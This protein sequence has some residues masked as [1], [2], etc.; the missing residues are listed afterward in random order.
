MMPITKIET[1]KT[2]KFR[3]KNDLAPQW[4]FRLFVYSPSG[5]GKTTMILNLVYKYLEYDTITIY[6]KNADQDTYEELIERLKEIE[7]DTNKQFTHIGS[8]ADEILPI[9]SYDAE[10][11]NLIIFDDFLIDKQANKLIQEYFIRSRH[12]N[13]SLMYLSQKYYEPSDTALKG[14]RDNCNYFALFKGAGGISLNQMCRDLAGHLSKDVFEKMYKQVVSKPF[15]FLVVDKKT[16]LDPL[17]FRDGWDG[18]YDPD[19]LLEEFDT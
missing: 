17:K 3:N 5:G 14:I 1:K 8:T 13:C 9:D 12:K 15:G 4:P 11:Q 16:E 6:A 19:G 10:L 18:L 2:K 7:E